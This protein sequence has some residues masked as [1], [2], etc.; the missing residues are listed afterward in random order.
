MA[1]CLLTSARS[2]WGT[3]QGRPP[4]RTRWWGNGRVRS[5]WVGESGTDCPIWPSVQ[6]RS[7]LDPESVP[8]GRNSLGQVSGAATSCSPLTQSLPPTVVGYIKPPD[9]TGHDRHHVNWDYRVNRPVR[10]EIF[11]PPLMVATGRMLPVSHR[12]PA[13]LDNFG[14]RITLFWVELPYAVKGS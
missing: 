5:Q 2:R 13:N 1:C 9:I 14:H 6:G 12:C 7:R 8:G 4:E 10:T 3:C 11:S